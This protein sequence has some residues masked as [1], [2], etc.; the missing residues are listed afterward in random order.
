M[1]WKLFCS[2]PA[3]SEVMKFSHFRIFKFILC[4]T[5]FSYCSRKALI[6]ES[7]RSFSHLQSRSSCKTCKS[8]Q[9]NYSDEMKRSANCIVH[10][11]LIKITQKMYLSRCD[12]FEQNMSLRHLKNI[13][14]EK[15]IL[16]ETGILQSNKGS[17]SSQ[18]D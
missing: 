8:T 12:D 16:E 4:L 18:S 13:K 15:K 3:I 14:K 5:T 17:D 2:T 7:T 10:F 9:N 1:E 11:L 6:V